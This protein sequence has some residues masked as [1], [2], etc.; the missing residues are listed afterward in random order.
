MNQN[1]KEKE[2]KTKTSM[3]FLLI[4][5]LNQLTKKTT[6]MYYEFINIELVEY[7]GEE[8]SMNKYEDGEHCDVADVRTGLHIINASRTT[9]V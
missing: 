2:N 3:I 1:I 7:N 6:T 8:E 9:Y 4:L 5:F